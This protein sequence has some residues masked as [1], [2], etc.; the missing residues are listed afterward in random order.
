M[1]ASFRFNSN[2]NGP[3]NN[4]G[5]NDA[6]KAQGFINMYLPGSEPGK[7]TK[8]GAIPLKTADADDKAMFDWAKSGDT[9]ECIQLQQDETTGEV[10]E[11]KVQMT[12]LEWI[13][14]NL[15][16]DFREV[17]V[18]GTKFGMPGAPKK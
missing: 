6:W 15:T 16:I 14:D 9:R 18:E 2:N 4:A 17:R 1:A 5:T 12:C 13:M 8:F 11:V 7:N 10:T 3:T